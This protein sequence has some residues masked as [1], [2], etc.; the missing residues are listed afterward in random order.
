MQSIEETVELVLSDESS[1]FVNIDDHL[2]SRIAETN[3][4]SF[5]IDTVEVDN[6]RKVNDI[7]LSF[8]ANL[9]F[10]GEQLDDKPIVGDTINMK[11][12]GIIVKE[13]ED[14]KLDNYNVLECEVED[15]N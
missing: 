5:G 15:Y 12:S 14:W 4:V 13:D 7:T 11:I 3:S 2:T 1:N 6:V 8:D 10:S 9:V